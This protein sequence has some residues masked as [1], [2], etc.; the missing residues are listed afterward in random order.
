MRLAR[1]VNEALRQPIALDSAVIAISTSIGVAIYPDHGT[2]ARELLA[3]ADEAL[4]RAKN[5][6]R[7]CAVLYKELVTAP[8]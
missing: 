4:Y 2:T 5:A 1:R 6:G 8:N 3:H 7:D